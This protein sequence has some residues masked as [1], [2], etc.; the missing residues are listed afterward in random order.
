MVDSKLGVLR[1]ATAAEK[2]T[3]AATSCKSNINSNRAVTNKNKIEKARRIA[4]ATTAATASKMIK[5]QQG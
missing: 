3:V 1:T 2:K 4:A 5:E